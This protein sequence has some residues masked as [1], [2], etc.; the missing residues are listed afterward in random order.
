[1]WYLI[2]GKTRKGTKEKKVVWKSCCK[3]F[4]H[5][6]QLQY[7]PGKVLDCGDPLRHP[8]TK[9]RPLYVTKLIFVIL[10]K[11]ATSC[12][13]LFI[14]VELHLDWFL[15]YLIVIFYFA[16]DSGPLNPKHC[17]PIQFVFL[18]E[19]WAQTVQLWKCHWG[20]QTQILWQNLIL[21][22]MVNPAEENL[23]LIW[24]MLL[25]TESQDRRAMLQ[26]RTA[27]VTLKGLCPIMK[28]SPMHNGK[29]GDIS[30]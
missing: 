8:V 9:S 24:M 12:K 25:P 14:V 26:G 22:Q 23:T 27:Q 19:L 11:W 29:V 13:Q 2:V 28:N 3:K 7:L 5:N 6:S 17:V 4:K 10:M 21:I 15:R 18:L 16:W 30:V 20:G 1:M